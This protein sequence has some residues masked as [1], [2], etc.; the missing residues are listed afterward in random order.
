MKLYPILSIRDN[1]WF[2]WSHTV[3]REVNSKI[4]SLFQYVNY[5]NPDFYEYVLKVTV[6]N[7]ISYVNIADLP[8][9]GYYKVSDIDLHD[10]LT[11]QVLDPGTLIVSYARA[12]GELD[13]SAATIRRQE[14][15]YTMQPFGWA[16]YY[17]V[18]G[19]NKES[20]Y[21]FD[22]R[23]QETYGLAYSFGFDISDK[24]YYVKRESITNWI[25]SLQSTSK[26]I[27]LAASN[28]S[29]SERRNWYIVNQ[30]QN[31][32]ITSLW[33]SDTQPL[34]SGF[35]YQ[36]D[37]N[38]NCEEIIFDSKWSTSSKLAETNI[39]I[40]T[41]TRIESSTWPCAADPSMLKLEVW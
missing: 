41:I 30:N 20:R 36:S 3:L 14:K 5:F 32:P 34:M 1:K 8:F 15:Y 16:S 12:E 17:L 9:H 27:N 22:S 39:A 13:N 31:A 24:R 19:G 25:Q 29:L 7:N 23:A 18:S 40:Y 2:N 21:I 38:W 37:N 28:G 35:F 11:N 33:M 6:K 4:F 26:E 10:T